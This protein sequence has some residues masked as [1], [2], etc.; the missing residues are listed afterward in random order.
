[1]LYTTFIIY[2]N[3]QSHVTNCSSPPNC[4]LYNP[5]YLIHGSNIDT[6]SDKTN[7]EIQGTL[8]INRTLR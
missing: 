6:I 3:L 7:K 2:I 8:D 4:N 5:G 1:M